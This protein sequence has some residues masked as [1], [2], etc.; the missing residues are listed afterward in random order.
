MKQGVGSTA[1][2]RRLAWLAAPL[3]LC[4]PAWG[5]VRAQTVPDDAIPAPR[6][7]N[8]FR[9]QRDGTIAPP[10]PPAATVPPVAT[11]PAPIPVPASPLPPTG[12][13]PAPGAAPVTTPPVEAPVVAPPEP[14]ASAPVARPTTPA[15]EPVAPAAPPPEVAAPPEIIP[16]QPA[17]VTNPVAPDVVEP[18][19]DA[20]EPASSSELN[21]PLLA[22]AGVLAAGVIGALVVAR[23]RKRRAQEAELE[24]ADEEAS[25]FV[26]EEVP[27]ALDVPAV[28]LEQEPVAPAVAAPVVRAVPPTAPALETPRPR[29]QLAFKPAAASATDERAAVQFVLTVANIG[30]A[31][32]RRVRMEARMFAMGEDHDAALAAFFGAPLER[33]TSIASAIPP[34]ISTDLR[35]QVTLPRAAVRPIRH[36]DRMLFVPVVAIN[37]LYEWDGGEQGQ[38]AMSYVIG[39][40]N[41]PPVAKMA[42]FRLDQGPRVYRE[43]G[44]REHELR[45]VA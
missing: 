36:A 12:S 4:V 13:G 21:L 37:L 32:A 24:K 35:T 39:R 34:G 30:N 19:A 25:S 27:P 2:T 6:N 7:L 3:A 14:R 26:V 41:R 8:D 11:P 31:P 33:A 9:I 1:T 20:S 23:R 45:R 17:P 40:E 22:L 43:V 44:H 28:P 18:V 15:P 29:I 10:T 42:P 5:P 38:T 16:E